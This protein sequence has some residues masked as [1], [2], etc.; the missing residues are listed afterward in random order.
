MSRASKA[1]LFLRKGLA[2]QFGVPGSSRVL[3]VGSF[4]LCIEHLLLCDLCW[5]RVSKILLSVPDG[6]QILSTA[7]C[8][9]QPH[10][11]YHGPGP[12]AN[13][14]KPLASEVSSTVFRTSWAVSAT[15]VSFQVKPEN[16]VREGSLFPAVVSHTGCTFPH[17]QLGVTCSWHYCYH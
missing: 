5:V 8:S 6:V 1:W 2:F 7:V 11:S 17:S 12:F 14:W 4:P 16:R 9:P 13:G 10:V 3:D 15:E